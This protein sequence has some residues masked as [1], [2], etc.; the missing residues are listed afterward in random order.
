MDL[1]ALDLYNE[2]KSDFSE[3]A[4]KFV[5]SSTGSSLTPCS[6]ECSEQAPE[7]SEIGSSGISC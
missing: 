3:L 7:L 1:L 5:G 4:P 2:G 6:G